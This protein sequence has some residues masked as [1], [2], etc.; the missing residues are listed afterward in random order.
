MATVGLVIADTDLAIDYLRD[1]DPGASW[2]Q[3][4]G[5]QGRLRLTSVTAF[6]LRVGSDFGGRR[7]RIEALLRGRTLP[8]DAPAA[9]EAGAIFLEL[10]REGEGI[11]IKDSLQAGICRR[12]DLPLATRNVKHFERVPGLTVAQLEP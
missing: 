3:A 5:S 4:A 2:I 10:E 6:E 12:F 11:G 7:T 1:H 9:M 8:L